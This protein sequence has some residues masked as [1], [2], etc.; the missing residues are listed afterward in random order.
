MDR[1]WEIDFARG[2]AIIMMVLSNFITDLQYFFD[3]TS[4]N[5]FWWFFARLTAFMFILIVGLSLT[6]SHS[7]TSEG[8]NK[9]L[10]RGTKIFTLGLI[11]TLSSYFFIPADYIRFGVLHL[12]GLSIILTY[13]FLRFKKPIIA[14]TGITCILLGVIIKSISIKPTWLFWLGLTASNFSSVDFFPLLP[15]LGIVLLGIWLGKTIY[16]KGRRKF[17]VPDWDNKISK[18]GRY[19]LY[20]YLAHQP[21]LLGILFLYKLI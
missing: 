7:R 14:V 4:Y 19:S 3:Y 5:T 21:V 9:Y 18:I 15:W 2:T 8:F 10:K 11:I 13:P 1:Y 20:I 17:I 12:I 6:I 16:P